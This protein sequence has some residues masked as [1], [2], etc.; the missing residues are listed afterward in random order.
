[1][2]HGVQASKQQVAIQTP[3]AGSQ[4]QQTRRGFEL[5]QVGSQ[6]SVQVA[7]SV[8]GDI[9]YINAA[10]IRAR[11]VI[12]NTKSLLPA[13]PLLVLLLSQFCVKL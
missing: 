9:L 11:E 7:Y 6:S 1:M 10:K 2:Q 12:V 3:R 4:W 13:Y 5:Y 8:F